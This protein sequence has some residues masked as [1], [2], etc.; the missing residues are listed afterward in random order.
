MFAPP[1][2]LLLICCPG[3]QPAIK[4]RE[5]QSVG[6]L[7]PL[8][9]DPRYNTILSLLPPVRRYMIGDAVKDKRFD[10]THDEK[11]IYVGWPRYH[12]TVG[13][14]PKL[15]ALFHLMDITLDCLPQEL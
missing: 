8:E 2:V 15:E 12:R 11:K 1:G 5:L 7:P 13:S 9:Q 14:D 4:P 3:E 10:L 6:L